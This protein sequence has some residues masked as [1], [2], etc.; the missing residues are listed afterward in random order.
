MLVLSTNFIL[1]TLSSRF[2]QK[3]NILIRLIHEISCDVFIDSVVFKSDKEKSLREKFEDIVFLITMITEKVHIYDETE[4]LTT[5][6]DVCWRE[7]FETVLQREKVVKNL[8]DRHQ[9]KKTIIIAKYRVSIR[10]WILARR[11]WKYALILNLFLAKKKSVIWSNNMSEKS[12]I[13]YNSVLKNFVNEILMTTILNE[14]VIE[15]ELEADILST[16][17]LEQI[18]KSTISKITFEN[19][20]IKTSR[21]LK[22]QATKRR[23]ITE[24]QF[25]H[26]DLQICII[27]SFFSLNIISKDDL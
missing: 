12:L 7:D 19:T 22:K 4:E 17:W 26:S 9:K 11:T 13:N 1:K 16:D 10:K 15:E 3:S 21:K 23:K 27:S 18:V 20:Q 8:H 5:R 2:S 25:L 14:T 6:A 24:N